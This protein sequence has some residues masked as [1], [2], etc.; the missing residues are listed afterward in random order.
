MG[1]QNANK[2]LLR[3]SKSQT[4]KCTIKLRTIGIFDFY[5]K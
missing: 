4:D 2:S 1:E 3:L 5:R